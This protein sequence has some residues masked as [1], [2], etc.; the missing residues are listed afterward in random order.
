VK[1][2]GC[3]GDPANENLNIVLEVRR[4][5]LTNTTHHTSPDG[6]NDSLWKM[7]HWNMYWRRFVLCV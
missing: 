3:F 1:Y 2:L 4:A 6:K 5:D 7:V